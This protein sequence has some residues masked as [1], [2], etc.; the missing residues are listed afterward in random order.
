M[1]RRGHFMIYYSK[2][3]ADFPFN[4]EF[5]A[6]CVSP[7]HL[8]VVVPEADA[9][10]AAGPGQDSCHG[11]E[12]DHHICYSLQDELLVHDGLTTSAEAKQ[13]HFN[14]GLHF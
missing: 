14:H 5:Q 4:A 1:T 9:D 6:G 13:G 3:V 2:H 8:V 10:G 12:V 7:S 11:V